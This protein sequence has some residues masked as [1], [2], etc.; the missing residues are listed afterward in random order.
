MNHSLLVLG[1]CRS[2]KTRYAL[3]RC[4]GSDNRFYLAT[5]QAFDTEMHD[6]IAAHREERQGLGFITIEEPSN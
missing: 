6:R 1:G 4:Q 3:S 2:G 5:A